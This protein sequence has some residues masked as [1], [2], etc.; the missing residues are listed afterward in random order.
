[1]DEQNPNAGEMP[2][3][4]TDQP[5]Q[6]AAEMVTISAAELENIR[7]ALKKANGEAAKHRKAQEQL[8]ADQKA[9]QQ[10]EMTELQKA[11]ARA[12]ELEAQL[13]AVTRRQM[14]SEIAAK[15]GLPPAFASRL[16]GETAEEMEADALAIL[17]ALPKPQQPAVL[18]PGIIPTNPGA[19]GATGESKEARRARLGF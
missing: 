19:N 18:S 3:S 6:T 12:A 9:K 13:N 11:Q 1:M 8:E 5:A 10:A 16:V 2:E 4:T 14:Q 7:M 15:V 17:E